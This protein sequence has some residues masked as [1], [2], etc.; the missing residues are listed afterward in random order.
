MT[1]R[2]SAD[3]TL[4]GPRTDERTR[5]RLNPAPHG[6]L[7]WGP[8]AGLGVLMLLLARHAADGI[9][10]PDALWHIMAGDHLRA[11][12]QFVGL[13]PFS[14]FTIKPWALTQWLPDLAM[15]LANQW[16]GLPGV[17]LL[18]QVGRL[19]VC[20]GIY[21]SCRRC[22]GP[23]AAALVT[24]IAVLG[25]AASLSPRPQLVGFALLTITTTAWLGTAQDLRPRWWLIPMSWVWASSHG[26][27]VVGLMVGVAATSGL[28]LDRRLDNG[29]AVRLAC[30][31]VLS[32]AAALVTPLGPRI[33]ET[34]GTV[35]AVSPYIQEWRRPDLTDP[36]TI[37]LAVLAVVVILA[38]ARWPDLRSWTH[39]AV[40]VVGLGWGCAYSRTV[41]IGAIILAPLAARA[42]ERAL[43]RELPEA[44]RER[45]F[46]ATL[47]AAASLACAGFAATGPSQPVGVPDRL[48]E[49]LR[50]LPDG[51]VV[52]NDDGLGGWLMWSFPNIQ[53]TGDTRAELYGAAGARRYLTA[54]GAQHGWQAAFDEYDPAV[55]LL[56]EDAP[57]V[58]ALQSDRGW[59][60]VG[61]D[62]GFALLTPHG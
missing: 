50:A 25:T 38:W 12:W 19:G 13:D 62:R 36:S 24:G 41:A 9:S 42:I 8:V 51:T 20:L 48:S 53:Q 16:A 22:S 44:G 58:S 11:T 30:L 57:L 7:R 47:V 14:P 1:N 21:V 3:P 56:P 39:A 10:D 33:L 55:A 59:A 34:F 32:G 4:A 46:V 18:A 31:V 6:L 28:K 2:S 60:I 29:Q 43:R 45:L 27:W 35:R 5:V 23:L 49:Q 37:A 26:S 40:L 52:F 61:R 17:A 54:V 15:S